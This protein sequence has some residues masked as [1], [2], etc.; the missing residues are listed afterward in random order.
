MWSTRGLFED[1][2]VKPQPLNTKDSVL[3]HN[4]MWHIREQWT[5]PQNGHLLKRKIPKKPFW[6]VQPLVSLLQWT[7]R[8]AKRSQIWGEI[9]HMNRS[10]I[11]NEWLPNPMEF[12]TLKNLKIKI[13]HNFKKHFTQKNILT[14]PYS[15][16]IAYQEICLSLQIGPF[17][18]NTLSTLKFH[19]ESFLKESNPS[20]FSPRHQGPASDQSETSPHRIPIP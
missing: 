2:G 8:S 7:C 15:H 19:S 17:K 14:S 6:F 3:S 4:S 13:I 5:P 1:P 10:L 16:V 20:P 18:S 12:S 11:E 9:A